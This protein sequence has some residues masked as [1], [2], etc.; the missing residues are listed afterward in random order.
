[1]NFAPPTCATCCA[2]EPVRGCW[3][4]VDC[5]EKPDPDGCCKHH[6]SELQ[7]DAACQSSWAASADLRLAG[8]RQA[9]T[10]A[11]ARSTAQ[12]GPQTTLRISQAKCDKQSG[13]NDPRRAAL[14]SAF[15]IWKPGRWTRCF[16][17]KETK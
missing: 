3:A 7:N 13:L 10:V 4:L 14:K 8:Q 5:G 1:M 15:W 12:T 17:S 6:Q 2:F 9:L 16:R 11:T